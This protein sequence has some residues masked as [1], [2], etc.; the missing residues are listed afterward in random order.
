MPI[1]ERPIYRWKSFWL[2]ILILSFLGWAWVKS[3]DETLIGTPSDRFAM[4]FSTGNGAFGVTH[5]NP[6][7]FGHWPV[8]HYPTP[9][10]RLQWFPEPVRFHST[11]E[12]KD[13]L[14]A[15]WLLILLFFNLWFILLLLRWWRM[16]IRSRAK[17]LPDS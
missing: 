8:I 13:L 9:R 11:L 12:S 14:V 3:M 6:P 4:S 16:R 2:G 15:Y 5:S 1:P 7:I 10:D 17:A